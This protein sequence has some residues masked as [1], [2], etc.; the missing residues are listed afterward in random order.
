MGIVARAK[1]IALFGSLFALSSSLLVVGL[2]NQTSAAETVMVGMQCNLQYQSRASTDNPPV[3]L[4]CDKDKAGNLVW[5]ADKNPQPAAFAVKGGL[6]FGRNCLTEKKIV[7]DGTINLA[8]LPVPSANGTTLLWLSNSYW[9]GSENLTAQ[10]TKLPIFPSTSPSA[11]PITSNAPKNTATTRKNTGTTS[12]ALL[13]TLSAVSAVGA[14]VSIT[15]MTTNNPPQQG[16]GNNP[17]PTSPESDFAQIEFA[18]IPELDEE[19]YKSGDSRWKKIKRS[20]DIGNFV[21]KF[22]VEVMN[23]INKVNKNFKIT[24]SILEDAKYLRALFGPLS[25][26]LYPAA[27]ITGIIIGS[28]LIPTENGSQMVMPGILALTVITSLGIIDQFAGVLAGIVVLIFQLVNAKSNHIIQLFAYTV[29]ILFLG[30]G[31]MLIIK[32][33]EPF[34]T[35]KK[36]NRN[37]SHYITEILIGLTFTFWLVDRIVKLIK[38]AHESVLSSQQE[39]KFMNSSGDITRIALFA[40]VF[41]LARYLLDWRS[42]THSPKQYKIY[43]LSPDGEPEI[44]GRAFQETIK[45]LIFFLIAY[46]FLKPQYLGHDFFF[47]ACVG[48]YSVPR[49]LSLTSYMKSLEARSPSVSLERRYLEMLISIAF[50]ITLLGIEPSTRAIFISVTSLIVLLDYVNLF[51]GQISKMLAPV[52][53]KTNRIPQTFIVTVSTLFIAAFAIS[54]K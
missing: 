27:I 16:G 25:S 15:N 19:E 26:L 35:N 38:D 51:W 41:F 8:C 40:L 9:P 44:F 1:S 32:V 54:Q 50:V 2:A 34:Y 10:P 7:N 45:I 20:K 22:E 49:I 39:M 43:S 37:L 6:A 47:W 42:K 23:F 28:H 52:L 48:I 13:T 36:E 11:A 14:A 21:T 3:A 29:F 46:V 53:S 33:V 12:L 18:I 4:V 24:A 5:N 17:R 31:P 30:F